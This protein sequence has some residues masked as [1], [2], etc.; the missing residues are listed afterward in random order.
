LA[1][2]KVLDRGGVASP[3]DGERCNREIQFVSET[4]PAES[5]PTLSIGADAF[6]LLR[7]SA[8]TTG[9]CCEGNV[10]GTCASG[11]W[12]AAERAGVAAETSG[13]PN[14]PDT[15]RGFGACD[16][17]GGAALIVLP[18]SCGS[19]ITSRRSQPER[20]AGGAA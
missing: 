16:A 15:M 1:G 2:A 14:R 3:A 7:E 20:S 4:L 10:R 13:G 5:G 9:L 8:I 6:A 19:P 17:T 12:P 11:D 18:L